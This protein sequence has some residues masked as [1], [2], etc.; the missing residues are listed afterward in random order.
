MSHFFKKFLQFLF[1][2]A[3]GVGIM[4]WVFVTQDKSYQAY[5]R[6]NGIGPENCIL[7][8]KMLHDLLEVKWYYI[9]IIFLSFYLSN[10]FR[11]LRWLIILEPLGYHPH[12]INAIGSVLVSYFANLGIPRS[13][14]FVRA[15]I[16]SRYEKIP[17]DKAFGTV[18]LDRMVDLISMAII[19]FITI[20]TQLSTF[21]VFYDKYLSEV[22]LTQKLILPILSI[23][24]LVVLYLTRNRWR[25]LLFFSNLKNRIRG[26]YEGL[27]VIKKI[28]QPRAFLLYTLLIWIWFYVMLFAA[29]KSFGPTS[30]LSMIAGLV[31]Y[32]FGS[33]GMLIPTPGGM[34][35]YHYLI[36]LV[37]AY[38][39]INPVDAFSFANISFFCAQFADNVILGLAALLVMYIF[40]R[41][42]K[43]KMASDNANNIIQSQG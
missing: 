5:C 25:N 34:G 21:N 38:Y 10:Y 42:L 19:I 31:I 7:W 36:I 16:I 2:L 6:E 13:G 29:L 27:V 17:L 28:K 26:F 4:Y 43:K 24:F 3:L 15:A 32:V 9:V 23:L 8:K 41:R 40:N 11:A 20:L 1:F 30:Q 22:S 35:S 12:K 33:L 39:N 14:E 18:V 37:L